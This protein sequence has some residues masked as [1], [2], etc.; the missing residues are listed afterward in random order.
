MQ[1]KNPQNFPW[2]NNRVS[3]HKI[4]EICL[5]YVDFLFISNQHL[6]FP[7]KISRVKLRG[8]SLKDICCG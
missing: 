3:Y 5:F 6:C 8:E 2:L 7:Q 1:I 4:N